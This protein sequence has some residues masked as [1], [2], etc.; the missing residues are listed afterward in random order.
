[1]GDIT[2][3][4]K[5]EKHDAFGEAVGSAANAVC[6]LTESAAQAAYLVGVSDPS[7]TAAVQGLVDQSQFARAQQAIHQVMDSSCTLPVHL[8][9]CLSR[10]YILRSK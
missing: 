1:M 4:A 10:S 5:A 2:R 3:D 7:S 9:V 8:S 6:A